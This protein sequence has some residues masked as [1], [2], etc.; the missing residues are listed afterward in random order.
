MELWSPA[1]GGNSMCLVVFQHYN[2]FLSFRQPS[3]GQHPKLPESRCCVTRNNDVCHRAGSVWE[4]MSGSSTE[5]DK[6]SG[7]F[8]EPRDKAAASKPHHVG[9]R[10]PEPG[11]PLGCPG[12]CRPG[13]QQERRGT[14]RD[15]DRGVSRGAC[16]G[17]HQQRVGK[18]GTG[19]WADGRGRQRA[20][21]R[22]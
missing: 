13:E 22:G 17:V 21:K 20:A 15:A 11:V 16:R 10:C 12:S 4:T 5:G 6:G 8:P 14:G 7:G 9:P 3:N 1:A 19:R 18:K 2:P